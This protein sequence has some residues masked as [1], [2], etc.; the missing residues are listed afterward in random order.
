MSAHTFNRTLPRKC[1]VVLTCLDNGK[2]RF[3]AVPISDD[4]AQS[5]LDE[6]GAGYATIL[7]PQ[8]ASPIGRIHGPGIHD[9]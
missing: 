6:Q 2:K 4:P 9:S 1:G 7:P 3:R 5:V 8:N